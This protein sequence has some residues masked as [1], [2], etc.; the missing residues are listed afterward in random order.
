VPRQEPIQLFKPTPANCMREFDT[1]RPDF[2]DSPITVDAGHVQLEA[3]LFNYTQSRPDSDGTVTEKFL[4]GS[5]NI[6]VGIT[7]DFEMD[8]LVQPINAVRKQV[9]LPVLFSWFPT[10]ERALER[11]QATGHHGAL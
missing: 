5:T 7:N 11:L 6:R 2:T 1:D 10:R 8:F 3:D 9:V 4:F